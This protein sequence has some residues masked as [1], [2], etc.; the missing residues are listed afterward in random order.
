MTRVARSRKEI[1]KTLRCARN[2]KTT[3]NEKRN[4]RTTKSKTRSKELQPAPSTNLLQRLYVTCEDV[5]KSGGAGDLHP[6][7]VQTLKLI[8]G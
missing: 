5:F 8:L 3:K 6:S 1:S 7:D 4:K 2:G